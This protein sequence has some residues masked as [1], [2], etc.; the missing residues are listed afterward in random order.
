MAELNFQYQ[1]SGRVPVDVKKTLG[2]L[3]VLKVLPPRTIF[4]EDDEGKFADTGEIGER[5]VEAFSSVAETPVLLNL[6]GKLD[7]SS[8]DYGDVLLL[9]DGDVSITP[10][11][12]IDANS[13]SYRPDNFGIKI[14]VHSF[15]V[16]SPQLNTK[17]NV[18][19]KKAEDS[20]G[21]PQNK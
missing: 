8:L 21:Q 9:S 15:K 16:G 10:W 13:Q 4:E 5:L 7:T 11:G 17:Q 18:D 3:T 20:K 2:T 12:N 19:V 6:E 1:N 14:T